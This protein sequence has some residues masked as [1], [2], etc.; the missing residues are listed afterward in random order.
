MNR[1]ARALSLASLLLAGCSSDDTTVAAP[2][3]PPTV[4][5]SSIT[6]AGGRT[7]GNG[8]CLEVGRDP[9]KTV[10]VNASLSE[11]FS[12][13]PPGTCGGLQLCGRLRF[14]L[15]P[16]GD[17]EA[18]KVE[19]AQSAVQVPLENVTLGSHVF[20]LELLNDAGQITLD[21]TKSPNVVSVTLDVKDPGGCGGAVDAGSDAAQDAGTDAAADAAE[22]AP[23]DAA[24]DA[25]G[26]AALDQAND[27]PQDAASDTSTD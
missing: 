8:S 10:V 18:L 14:R 6:S 24:P 23:L 15:D 26:D 27:A 3:T 13:R 25:P 1:G 9:A 17:S 19:A 11:G 21:P 22:D 2:V 20:Q 5:L 16:S 7:E 4:A 12:L